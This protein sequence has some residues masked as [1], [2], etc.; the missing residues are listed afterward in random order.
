MP[1]ISSEPILSKETLEISFGNSDLCKAAPSSAK[2][3]RFFSSQSIFAPRS[4]TT[5]TPFLLGQNPAK[6]GLETLSIIFKIIRDT[7]N[8]T[9]VLPADKLMLEF[10]FN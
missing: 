2:S 10:P 6:A 7:T 3:T 9:P 8:K 4:K 5:L 1:L